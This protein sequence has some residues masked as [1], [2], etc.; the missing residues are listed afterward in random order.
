MYHYAYS[1]I[2]VCSPHYPIQFECVAT[3]ILFAVSQIP[4]A[5]FI[6]CC[7]VLAILA[8]LSVYFLLLSYVPLLGVF[9]SEENRTFT[10]V[11]AR[12]NV[13]GTIILGSLSSFGS[14]TTAWGYFPLS[15]GKNR[16][17]NFPRVAL[18]T[19]ITNPTK[20]RKTP[21]QVEVDCV[22]PSLIFICTE[23]VSKREEL[24]LI[25]RREISQTEVVYSEIELS[26]L[27]SLEENMAS[28]LRY[29]QQQYTKVILDRTWQGCLFVLMRHATGFYCIFCSFVVWFFFRVHTPMY[30]QLQSLSNVF[31]P[32]SHPTT[33]SGDP[34]PAPDLL[35]SMLLLVLHS[36]S[37]ITEVNI[38][39]MTHQANLVLMGM[40]ITGSI[41]QV[42]QGAARALCATPTSRNHVA[43]LVL[44]VLAQLMVRVHW[45]LT[46]I[47]V[48][49]IAE[50]VPPQGIYLLSML[51]QLRTSFPP[52]VEGQ[53]LG[54]LHRCL[55]MR[56]LG[57]FSIGAFSQVLAWG[58]WL[59]G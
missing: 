2:V 16:H 5:S 48:V 35:T 32:A 44:L 10:P 51:V 45:V 28:E 52:A 36:S 37:P 31:L 20:S 38:T 29:L 33:P 17:V 50:L 49:I 12:Y 40:I 42:L 25:K 23:L 13:L 43:S 8:L 3:Y 24:T 46:I 15:C 39:Y 7:Q 11:M 27:T 34:K 9:L 1:C 55:L 22:E 14:V 41:W 59:S 19:S 18:P 21:T 57:L 4:T 26:A 56:C 54:Y 58:R 53:T 30:L 6:S 47:I